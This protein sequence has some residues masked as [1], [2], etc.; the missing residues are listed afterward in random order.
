MI[1]ATPRRLLSC[2]RWQVRSVRL[3][4]GVI[5]RILWRE[6]F[7]EA[8][9]KPASPSNWTADRLRQSQGSIGPGHPSS[10]K[11]L[12]PIPILTLQVPI[13]LLLRLTK[14]R[15]KSLAD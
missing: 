11:G 4:S 3:R 7:S 9:G 15:Y 13:A 6:A 10:A 1:L 2:E 8:N 14:M 5:P 12:A